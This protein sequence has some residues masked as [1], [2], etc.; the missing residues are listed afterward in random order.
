[1]GNTIEQLHTSSVAMHYAIVRPCMVSGFLSFG[2]ADIKVKHSGNGSSSII[3]HEV[4]LM[5]RKYTV[6]EGNR[7]V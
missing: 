1:M 7:G 6:K 3:C 5:Q 2:D 4:D